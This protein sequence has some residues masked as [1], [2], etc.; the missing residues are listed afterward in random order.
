[1]N[2]FIAGLL[3]M[4]AVIIKSLEKVKPGVN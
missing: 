4:T 2:V 3:I 1:M